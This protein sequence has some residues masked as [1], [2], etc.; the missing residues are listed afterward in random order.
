M[1]RRTDVDSASSSHLDVCASFSHLQA[2]PT[3]SSLG[4]APLLAALTAEMREDEYYSLHGFDRVPRSRLGLD[5][6]LAAEED[7]W[8]K[9]TIGVG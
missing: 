8:V 2:L 3:W 1:P 4:L 5:H 9:S 7:A 6:D